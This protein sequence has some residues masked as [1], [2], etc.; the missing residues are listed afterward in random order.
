MHGTLFVASVAALSACS[1]NY[2]NA[3]GDG[4]AGRQNDGS[5]ETSSG[6]DG[7]VPATCGATLN[8]A[9]CDLC[10]RE[11]CCSEEMLCGESLDCRNCL[12][13]EQGCVSNC[14]NSP[15]VS[16]CEQN[17]AS[18]NQSGCTTYD[19]FGMCL[20]TNCNGVCVIN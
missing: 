20:A 10:A 18:Q 5:A 15:C 11:Y 6:F 3:S 14:A 4:G 8:P 1:A 16:S 13:C 9:A 12:T 2:Q 19:M 7:Q 17:C